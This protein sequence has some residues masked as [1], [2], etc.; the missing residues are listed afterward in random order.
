ME[1]ILTPKKTTY[2]RV[3]RFHGEGSEMLK[4]FIVNAFLTIIS[5]GLYYPWAKANYLKYYYNQTEFKNSRFN[6]SGTGKEMFRGFIKVYLIF[7]IIYVGSYFV[8]YFDEIYGAIYSFI[9]YLILFLIM[10]YAIHGFLRYRTSR[11]SWRSIRFGYRGERAVFVKKYLLGLFLCI[12]TLGV[13]WIW[14]K[15]DM[16]K[17]IFENIKFGN[18]NTEY[19]ADGS[20]LFVIHL[21]GI[22]LTILTF[23]I[24]QFWYEKELFEYELQNIKMHQNGNQI[25]FNTIVDG[26]DFLALGLVNTILVIFTL[27]LAIP[28]V[29][30]RTINFYFENIWM[31][32]NFDENTLIQTEGHYNNATGEEFIDQSDMD[33]GFFD[34]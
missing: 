25:N 29:M 20:D 3:F 32:N 24:Y 2:S 33:L 1:E 6:F 11:S 4:M 15:V 31:Q 18:V 22:I 23:G 10:P 17:Y 12:I 19:T 16:K 8:Q 27:G 14:F 13:Y 7:I 21:K 30:V 9:G 34:F 5:L 26:I 28:W